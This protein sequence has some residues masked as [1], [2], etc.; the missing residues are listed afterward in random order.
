MKLGWTILK[1]PDRLWVQIFTSKYFKDTTDGLQLRRK[2]GGSSL[3]R[4]IRK[5]WQDMASGCQHSIRNGKD[6][7]FWTANWLDGGITL[8]DH[9]TRELTDTELLCSVSDMTDDS[10]NWDWDLL[11]NCLPPT[12]VNQVAGMGPPKSDGGED[13]M[14]WGPDPRGRFSIKS[15]YDIRAASEE[16]SQT[17]TWKLVWKW[18]GPSRIKHFLWLATHNRLLT[19]A[20]RRRRHMT[21]C[22][23]C[24][25]CPN[26]SETSIHVLRD[27]HLARSVW[28]ALL[29]PGLAADFFT[30]DIQDWISKGIQNSDFSLI[31]GITLWILWKARNEDIFDNRSVT[32]DQLRLRVLNWTAGVRETMKA[33]S[34]ALS[35]VVKR[36]RET[37]LKWI[38][39]PDDWI[40]VNCDG[41]VIHPH[42]QA[43]AGGIIRDSS[44]RRLAVFAANLGTC[45]ITRAEL[46]AAA[47][48]LELAWEMQVRKVHL[49]TDSSTSVLAITNPQQEDSRHG[50]ILQHIRQLMQ[51]N[52][53]VT[54]SHIYRERNRVADLLAHHGHSLSLGSHFNF[55]C[56]SDIER[57]TCSDIVGVC[58]PRLI[59]SNE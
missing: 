16:S 26:V 20:E 59:S 42:G 46:R 18:E 48:G 25:H 5:V 8:V 17:N 32:S 14:I 27:C 55:V 53:M 51:R 49:Q 12:I 35:G 21:S 41:S 40:T 37:L 44:G 52:W 31:F 6:T 30:G 36:S 7:L 19:N 28:L 47:I 11:L 50:H 15:A 29:P 22:E 39:A 34:R 9:A 24:R 1:E 2:T 38:P 58:F 10:G 56:S 13:D 33:E 4:G 54:V 23:F 45:T 43:A 57:A 3:W